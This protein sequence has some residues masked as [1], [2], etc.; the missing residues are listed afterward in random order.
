[1]LR[2]IVLLLLVGVNTS[3]SAQIH[4]QN[5][6]RIADNSSYCGKHKSQLTPITV[7][8]FGDSTTAPRDTIQ[9]FAERLEG[10][11]G[12]GERKI[13][14][15]NAGVPA[16]TTRQARA[17]FL[18]DVVAHHPE[19][20][21]ILFGINDSAVDVFDS[22]TTPRISLQE[23]EENLRWM[24]SELR[25]RQI[26]PILLTPNPVAW[27]DQLRKLYS[28]APYRP[29][30][31]DGWNVL[32]KDYAATVRD[33]G[34]TERVPVVDSYQIFD[35]ITSAPGHARNDLTLDG[36]H[37]NNAGHVLLAEHILHILR[38]PQEFTAPQTKVPC[39]CNR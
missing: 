10:K 35:S 3:G 22:K 8:A 11:V 15:I 31:P 20:V 12:Y 29:E 2:W 26:R 23:Y 16:N 38:D 21:T 34:S 14:V 36:M 7:V 33:V 5:T 28:T 25:S 37:P 17:R 6:L 39:D 27:T 9:V 19:F 32:L 1:M 13:H 18:T 4:A 24:I 30:A